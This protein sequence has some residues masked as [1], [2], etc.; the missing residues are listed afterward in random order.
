LRNP[1]T[2]IRG[3]AYYLKMRWNS[4]LDKRSKEMLDLIESDVEYSNKIVNDLLDFSKQI[5]LQRRIV[6]IKSLVS[7]VLSETEAPKKVKI[8]DLTR[9]THKASLDADQM[10]RV[11]KN[12]IKNAIDAMPKGGTLTIKSEKA[13]DFI[14]IFV[15][16]TGK[17]IPKRNLDKMFIPL[18]TTKAKGVGLGLPICKRLVEAH[19]GTI[20]VES[21]EG[22]GTCLTITVPISEQKRIGGEKIWEEK[23][24]SLLSMMTPALEKFS[25]PY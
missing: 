19:G 17:G 1:L 6:D 11:L 13:K 12:L 5:R 2:G 9:R 23:E 7:E 4:K 21:E 25:Q 24:T 22:Q 18:F 16:D 8:I 3:A 15:H 14:K 20:T 10:K